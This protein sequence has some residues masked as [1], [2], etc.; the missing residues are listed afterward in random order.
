MV[1]LD[2]PSIRLA[3]SKPRLWLQLIIVWLLAALTMAILVPIVLWLTSRDQT[4]E[5]TTLP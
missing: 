5:G 4:V 1:E 2:H 3:L